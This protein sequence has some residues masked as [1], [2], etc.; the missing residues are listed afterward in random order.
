MA[1]I[2]EHLK[3]AAGQ[4]EYNPKKFWEENTMASIME[5]FER[6]R[7]AED[8]WKKETNWKPD[9]MIPVGLAKT[10]NLNTL[11]WICNT[12]RAIGGS[13]ANR[14]L[15]QREIIIDYSKTK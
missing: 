10:E 3:N 7:K 5:D 9:F 1:G 4:Y 14:I 11:K 12:Y 6:H 8:K 2:I 13:E 15:R